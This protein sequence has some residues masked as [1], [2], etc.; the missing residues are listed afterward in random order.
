VKV[1]ITEEQLNL[2][3]EDTE[4]ITV[5]IKYPD[6][7]TIPSFCGGNLT[8][9]GCRDWSSW[10]A[11]NG[12]TYDNDYG[13]DR[14]E[15]IYPCGGTNVGDIVFVK[16]ISKYG[17]RYTRKSGAVKDGDSVW[18][19]KA[20]QIYPHY[21]NNTL[22]EKKLFYTTQNHRKKKTEKH[23]ITNKKMNNFFDDTEIIKIDSANKHLF[24]SGPTCDHPYHDRAIVAPD[25]HDS[26]MQI[27][28]QIGKLSVN[29][30]Y[31]D[32]VHQQMMGDWEGLAAGLGRSNHNDGNALDI[33]GVGK[34]EIKNNVSKKWDSASEETQKWL[35]MVYVGPYF[36]WCPYGKKDNVHFTYGSNYKSRDCK[37]NKDW[38]IA[39]NFVGGDPTGNDSYIATLCNKSTGSKLFD[40]SIADDMSPEMKK[41]KKALWDEKESGKYPGLSKIREWCSKRFGGGFEEIEPEEE[42]LAT[43][44]APPLGDVK[45][46]GNN[47]IV[48]MGKMSSKLGFKLYK[49]DGN[50]EVEVA[51]R[52]S[53]GMVTKSGISEKSAAGIRSFNIVKMTSNQPILI[54]KPLFFKVCRVVDGLNIDDTT[55]QTENFIF[56]KDDNVLTGDD[57]N[58]Y[59]FDPSKYEGEEKCKPA[60]TEIV[61]PPIP[62]DWDW[63][64]AKTKGD[65]YMGAT[66]YVDSKGR[67]VVVKQ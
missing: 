9:K 3:I 46:E 55:M 59:I 67:E 15:F 25:T 48:N 63:C 10:K 35:W 7:K 26:I 47:L 54:G 22:G 12:N 50:K 37:K 31:R 56:D 51:F 11:P 61:S 43:R 65:S 30:A 44:V 18:R 32:N 1:L 40:D 23:E 19:K 49:M 38:A 42:E 20:E 24:I 33:G 52:K 2:I 62:I 17:D 4:N 14:D 45:I 39:Y 66:I 41:L 53:S 13:D 16:K 36:N 8:N 21:L 64:D 58:Y 57:M 27:Q 34:T 6:V 29:S 60:F 28:N 5:N